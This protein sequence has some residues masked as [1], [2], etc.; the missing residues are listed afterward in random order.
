MSKT[1]DIRDTIET[2][3]NPVKA[4]RAKCLDCCGNQYSEVEKCTVKA[5]A[6]HPFR[7]GKNP[8]RSKRE[9][10]PEAKQ[11]ASLRFKNARIAKASQLS[12]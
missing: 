11:A 7:F 1:E 12:V 9:L 8:Y 3:T 10:S 4:I 6:L 5:C 2:S